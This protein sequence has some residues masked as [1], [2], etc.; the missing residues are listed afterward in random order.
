M[1]R[2]EF[3]Y[4]LDE[5]GRVVLPPKFRR[6]LGDAVIVTRGFDGCVWVYPQKG[7]SSVEK[8]LRGLPL[9]RRD[10]QRFLLAP[11]R[12]V[13][14]DRQGRITLPEALREY[15]EI[16]KDVVVIGL[17]NRLEIWSEARWKEAMAKAQREAAEI[18]EQIDVSL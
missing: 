17:I 3:H 14:V 8:V 5:K 4:T 12:E 15:A 7:W 9:S 2:G 18:A 16:D 6:E 11:A 13:E 1:F 10:F